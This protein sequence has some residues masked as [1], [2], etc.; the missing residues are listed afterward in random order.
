M[1]RSYK[2]T[3][4]CGNAKRRKLKNYAN[5]VIRRKGELF[6]NSSYKKVYG[7]YNI[8]DYGSTYRSFE[9]YYWFRL[10]LWYSY[11]QGTA[12]PFPNRDEE[13]EQYQKYYIR[14]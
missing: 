2:K 10:K 8:C 5:R 11:W 6:Q 12:V 3:P 1:S 14:K 13:Y 7:S 9:E 4:Y